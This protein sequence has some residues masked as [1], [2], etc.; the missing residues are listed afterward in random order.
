MGLLTRRIGQLLDE[1]KSGRIVLPA[2]GMEEFVHDL[3]LIRKL[4][5]GEVDL[6]SCTTLVRQL[7]G[8]ILAARQCIEEGETQKA[9]SSLLDEMTPKK[10]VAL[11]REY[12]QLL[13]QFFEET[14]GTTAEQFGK[15][16]SFGA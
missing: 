9:G 1:L 3:E 5:N 2:Q 7:A 11:Q 8:T 12:F 10:F 16:D 14:T 13:N 4:P 15:Y 6:K